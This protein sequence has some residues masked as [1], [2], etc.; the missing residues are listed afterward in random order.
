MYI[1]TQITSLSCTIHLDAAPV[2]IGS[3]KNWLEELE[4]SKGRKYA[5]QS[6]LHC[7][8]LRDLLVFR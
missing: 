1:S 3:K 8:P 6:Y 5:F 4:K 7:F 2:N